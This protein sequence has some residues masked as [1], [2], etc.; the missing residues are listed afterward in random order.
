M[1]YGVQVP[2]GAPRF[3]R[4]LGAAARAEQVLLA[5]RLAAFEASAQEIHTA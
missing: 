5:E 4:L 1:I 2:R 3:P